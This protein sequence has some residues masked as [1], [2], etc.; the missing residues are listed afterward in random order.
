M[1]VDGGLI[2][3]GGSGFGVMLLLYRQRRQPGDRL[4]DHQY[5]YGT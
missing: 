2:S 4:R 3:C 5:P 1:D